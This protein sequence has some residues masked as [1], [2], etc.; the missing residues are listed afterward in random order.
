MEGSYLDFFDAALRPK[1]SVRPSVP[2]LL[3]ERPVRLRIRRSM[4]TGAVVELHRE[5]RQRQSR[6]GTATETADDFERVLNI[7]HQLNN[8]LTAE[9]LRAMVES[10]DSG[11][12]SLV[13]VCRRF[14]P[15]K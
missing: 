2:D 4:S 14:L 7:A 12:H 3:Q 13:A 9:Y 5:L 8:H 10:P 6:L 11:N 1:L 15:N